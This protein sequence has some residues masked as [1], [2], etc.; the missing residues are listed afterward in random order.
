MK[1]KT[2]KELQKDL[3]NTFKCVDWSYPTSGNAR[4]FGFVSGCW[5]VATTTR[6]ELPVYL[7]GFAERGEAIKFAQ[8]LNLEWSYVFHRAYPDIPAMLPEPISK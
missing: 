8:S 4:R 1:T 2:S 3:C 7:R 5:T 6:G